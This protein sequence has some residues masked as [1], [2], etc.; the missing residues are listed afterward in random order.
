MSAAISVT[1]VEG[2]VAVN[3]VDTVRGDSSPLGVLEPDQQMIYD[4]A[5]GETT[6]HRVEARELTMWKDGVLNLKNISFAEAAARIERWYSV[7]IEI[8]NPAIRQCMVHASFENEPLSKVLETLGSVNGFTYVLHNKKVTIS[9]PGCAGK[10]NK[11]S[12]TD[13]T[14]PFYSMVQRF[15]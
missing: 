12:E 10:E 15:T 8:S 11:I 6:V 4:K 5:T 1:L 2:R 7:K 3:R 14:N 13:S 9:G